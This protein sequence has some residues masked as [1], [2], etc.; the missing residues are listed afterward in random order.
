MQQITTKISK[1]NTH[2]CGTFRI[3]CVIK[4]TANTTDCLKPCKL[5]NF[6]YVFY[7]LKPLF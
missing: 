4:E 2:V 7:W 6:G 5:S 1:P 3:T